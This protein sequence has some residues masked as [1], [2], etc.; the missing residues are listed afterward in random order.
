MLLK[1]EIVTN[2]AVIGG[3][4]ANLWDSR[5]CDELTRAPYYSVFITDTL[6]NRY[7]YVRMRPLS[8]ANKV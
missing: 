2:I 4:L 6:V 7:F 5:V 1:D 8:E 3:K